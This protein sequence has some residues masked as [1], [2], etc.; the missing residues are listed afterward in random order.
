MKRLGSIFGVIILVVVLAFSTAYSA[1]AAPKKYIYSHIMNTDHHFHDVSQ[2][3]VDNVAKASNGKVVIDYHRGGDLGDWISQLDQAM[4]GIIPM[5]LTWNNSELNPKLDLAI[6]GFV[7]DSWPAAKKV[8][9]PNGLLM[10]EFE[11]MFDDLGLI[12]AGTVPNGFGVFV[13][14]KGI[15]VPLNFPEDAKGFKMRIPQFVMGVTR[16]K[17]LGF[18]PITIPFSELHTAMQ[19]GTVDGRA[20]GP[21]SEQ[22]MF[23]DILDAMVY[24]REHIDFTFF[25][26]SKKWYSKLPKEEQVWIMDSAK[27]ACA[28]AWDNIERFEKED[29]DE[30]KKLGIKV[31]TLSPEQQAKYKA[32]VQK[33]EWPVFEKVAGK[34]LMDKVKKAS[35]VK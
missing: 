29:I 35:T 13:V 14:R 12:V 21:A 22:P 34:E 8:Y 7:A 28:Y 10:P 31:V 32:I 15:K 16:Y 2:V 26:I 4:Q 6:L 1:E 11:K 19:T 30:C 18:A 17:A 23:A 24:T 20:Y 33:A 3:F 5:T 25:V 27:K 9:G